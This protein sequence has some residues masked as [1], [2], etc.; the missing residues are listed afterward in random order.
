M[1]RIVTAFQIGTEAQ[2]YHPHFGG[3]PVMGV[4]VPLNNLAENQLAGS[5]HTT[6]YKHLLSTIVEARSK[7]GLSQAQLAQRIGKPASFVG[8]YE[9][10]ER[11]LDVI[12]LMVVLNALDADSTDF[13]L[14]LRKHLPE[15][16]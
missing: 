7:A 5:V 12:E 3:K 6:A 10:G 8:K 9:V 13:I 14:E 11:R 16:L 15:Q 1:V 4:A 2:V